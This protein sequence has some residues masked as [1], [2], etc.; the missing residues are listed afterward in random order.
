MSGDL[1]GRSVVVTAGGTREPLDPVRFIGNRSSG[2]MGNALAAAAHRRGGTVTLITAAAPPP[3]T[4]V[5]VVE[6]ETAE[7]MDR[8]VREALRGAAV[9]L[10]AAAVADYRP[11]SAAVTKLPK[12]SE[13]TLELV[14]TLDILAGLRQD[15]LR[16]G[17]L[18]VGFAAETGDGEARAR[19]KLERKGLDLV[20][21]NDVATPGIGMGAAD[22]AVTILDGDG[23]VATVSKRP[24]A[25][26]AE[27]I[28]DVVVARLQR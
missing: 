18:M 7:E 5:A 2:L 28:L 15:P 22:N 16:R 23:V 3:A 9:L 4:G 17:V 25:A 8:A 13:L 27:A 26:V 11:R 24:K 14:G 10:M 20:V 21:V 12:R 19:R 1:A 6:V